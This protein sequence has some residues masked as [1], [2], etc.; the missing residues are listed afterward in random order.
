MAYL[1]QL[2]LKSSY[3][4]ASFVKYTKVSGDGAPENDKKVA[5]PSSVTEGMIP[6][7][8]TEDDTSSFKGLIPRPPKQVGAP[9]RFFSPSTA[10]YVISMLLLRLMAV[11]EVSVWLGWLTKHSNASVFIIWTS[12][13][14]MIKFSVSYAFRA[15]VWPWRAHWRNCRLF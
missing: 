14:H 12:E 13:R 5:A 8:A 3:L 10:Q 7:L 2:F 6:L 4:F 15:N 1:I 9:S 11:T